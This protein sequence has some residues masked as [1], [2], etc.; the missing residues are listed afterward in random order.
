MIIPL[1]WFVAGLISLIGGAELLVRYVSKLALKLG[2]SK[3]VIALTVVAFGTSAPELAVSIQASVD[4][5]T[6]LMLGNIVGS[7]ISN[8][9]FI[10]GLSAIFIPLKVHKNLIKSDVPIMLGITLLIYFLSLNGSLSVWESGLL[11][12]LLVI[13]LFFLSRKKGHAEIPSVPEEGKDE[14]GSLLANIL[15]SGLGLVLLVTGARW[16]INSSLIFAEM[17]GISELIIG[18]TVVAIG[19]SLPEIVTSLVAAIRGERDIA[20]GSV[21]GSNILNFL[22]VLGFA[23]LF[24]PNSIPVQQSLLDFDFL[25]L[26]AATIACIPIFYTG[27]KI[28]RW[29][30]ALFLFFYF[31]YLFYL[32]LSTTDHKFLDVFINV[33]IFFVIPVAIITILYHSI[34]EWIWRARYVGLFKTRKEE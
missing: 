29:E 11:V 8:T 23:G 33:M 16:L 10:L 1:L 12:L 18:L 26:I 13:Y 4:G 3:L 19:T 17:A 15:F 5:Q 6:D 21:V 9:L 22:A 31:A 24:S 27:H 14:G 34:S 20:V 25:V 28:V 7:N 30:G 2:V 32:F